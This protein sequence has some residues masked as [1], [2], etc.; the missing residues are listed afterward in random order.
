[1]Y[2][3]VFVDLLP[4]TE[5]LVSV[6]CVYEQRESSPLIGS[7]KTGQSQDASTGPLAADSSTQTPS[8]VSPCSSGFASRPALLRDLHQL[9]H[10]PLARPSEQNQRLPHPPPDGQRRQDQRRAAAAF[11]EPLHPDESDSRHRISGL[12]LRCERRRGESAA[13]REAED[14]YE[15]KQVFLNFNFTLSGSLKCPFF[16][17]SL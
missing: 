12:H 17:S 2:N 9:L 1:M 14:Q 11:Q 6:V 16:V 8:T 13:Q 3:R 7:Q 4:H 10:R 5:Y 15:I